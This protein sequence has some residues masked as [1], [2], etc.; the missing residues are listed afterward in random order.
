VRLLVVS[1]CPHYRQD[2]TYFAYGP[3]AKEIEVW[4]DLFSEIVIAAPYRSGSPP[5]ESCRI[6]R[7]NVRVAPQ[8]EVGGVT[9][10]QKVKIFAALP[11]LIIGLTREM[12]NADAIHVR[13]P[14]NLGLLGALLAPLFSRY[15]IAKY[16]GQWDGFP[17]EEWTIRLQRLILR[18]RWW[19]GPVTVYGRSAQQSR[20][21][22]EFFSA[23][24]SAEQLSR[25]RT[26]AT[27]RRPGAPPTVAFTGRLTKAKNVDVLIKAVAALKSE[28]IRLQTLIV[29]DGPER[30]RLKALAK[31]LT[32][33][34]LVVFTGGVVPERVPEFLERSDIFVLVSE[35][36]GWPKAIAEAM[37]FG[38][39]CIGSDR[40]LVPAFLADGRGL[41]VRPRDVTGLT[42]ILRRVATSPDEY[43]EM[44]RR[45]SQWAQTYSLEHLSD[46][47][48][49]LIKEWWNLSDAHFPSPDGSRFAS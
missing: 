29:G 8:K 22:I 5:P 41:T 36:E 4:A 9:W 2:G 11:A 14:G 20:H 42:Q 45:S 31:V 12:W 30:D 1:H 39:V 15:L 35:T 28:S 48:R 46:A 32:V 3:Y 17:G 26:R 37:A 24:F 38:L 18:S 43:E 6:N 19:R 25:A 44:R 33:E 23:M 13:C 47:L 34:D 40:G 16:A 21:I 7:S 10:R 49:T 27:E